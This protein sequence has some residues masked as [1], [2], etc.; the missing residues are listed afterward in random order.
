MKTY[1]FTQTNSGGYLIGPYEF[2]VDALSL[3]DAW[4][5]LHE[6][7]WFDPHYCECCG[8][9][10]SKS[11]SSVLDSNGEWDYSIE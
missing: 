7:C 3:D 9:R 1:R 2:I 5:K 8:P 4:T 11:N 10:W 6:Q